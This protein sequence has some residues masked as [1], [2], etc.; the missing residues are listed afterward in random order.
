M[1]AEFVKGNEE[2]RTAL[3]NFITFVND[4]VNHERLKWYL[5]ENIEKE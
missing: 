5:A 4:G 3:W 2:K 1:L